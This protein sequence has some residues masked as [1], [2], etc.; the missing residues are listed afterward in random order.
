MTSRAPQRRR[1][2]GS[3]CDST[4]PTSARRNP[5]VPLPPARTPAVEMLDLLANDPGV[6]IGLT[7]NPST[8]HPSRFASSRGVPPPMN[9]SAIRRP[10]RSLLS[11]NVSC[12]GRCPNSARS[13]PRNNVPA[14]R[15]PLV[16]TDDRAIVL[17]YLLL[18]ERQSAIIETSKSLSMLTVVFRSYKAPRQLR[19]AVDSSER[20]TRKLLGKRAN[21][22]RVFGSAEYRSLTTKA[23]DSQ[24]SHGP[25]E[26]Q[27]GHRWHGTN[28]GSGT[29]GAGAYSREVSAE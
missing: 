5:R 28:P 4:R 11:K 19:Y 2:E 20:P 24:D 21:R 22:I 16:N 10:D 29:R 27:R 17:L 18:P 25:V 13:R 12:S 6:A 3:R 15:E 1:K 8:S 26:S 7:S 9:G 23:V 14:A